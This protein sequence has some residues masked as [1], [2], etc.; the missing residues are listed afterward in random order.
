V[1]LA[2]YIGRGGSGAEPTPA[3]QSTQASSRAAAKAGAPVAIAGVRDFDPQGDPP[4]E[5]PDLADLAVDGKPGTAWRTSTYY[6]PLEEQKSGVGLLVDL[7]RARSVSDV[8]VT[9]LGSP[10]EERPTDLEIL[11]AP[12][13]AT[14]PTSTDGLAKVATA[15]G[16]GTQVDLALAKD[17]TTRWMVVWFTKLPTVPGGFQGR[18]A[19]ISVRS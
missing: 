15:E 19:E 18:I 3:E 9:L 1:V 14:A 5:N 10:T 8:R 7:G 13:D 16:A 2:F 17:V 12:E 6:D 4:E 11:A